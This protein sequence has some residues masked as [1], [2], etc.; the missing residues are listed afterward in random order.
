MPEKND[1][2][3]PARSRSRLGRNLGIGAGAFFLLLLVLYFVVTSSTFL[4]GV[5]APQAGKELGGE[6][7]VGEARI[8]PFSQVV[9]KN[10]R[11]QTSG[12]EP[13]MQ[14]EEVR[15]RYSLRDIL[16]GTLTVHEVTLLSPALHIIEREDGSS[17]LEPVLKAVRDKEKK[18]KKEEPPP[19]LN[20]K[21][22]TLKDGS[23]RM[24]RPLKDGGRETIEISG[25]QISL[26]QLINGQ[27]GK[28]EIASALALDRPTLATDAPGGRDTLQ[29]KL[30]GGFTFAIDEN[31]APLSINGQTRLE[32]NQAGGMLQDLSALTAILDC[33]LTPTEIRNVRLHFTQ[34]GA[35]LGEVR[36]RG[37]FDAENLEAKLDVE[38]SSID[39][40]VLN[41]AGATL[42]YDF[43]PTKI[44]STN[45][46]ELAR[47]GNAVQARGQVAIS[48]FSVTQKEMTT[49]PLDLNVEYSIAADLEAKTALVE[50]FSLQGDQKQQRFLEGQLA[51]PMKIAWGETADAVDESAFDLKLT[52]LNLADWRLFT[53]DLAPDGLVDLDLKL[54]SQ[55]AGKKLAIELN[56]A[57]D[58]LT[59]QL[60]TNRLERASIRLRT[61][62]NV[63]DFKQVDLPEYRF[64][65]AQEKEPLITAQGQARYH[66]ETQAATAELDSEISLP[67]LVQFVGLPELSVQSGKAQFKGRLVQDVTISGGK[68]NTAQSVVGNVT[69]NEFT[70]SYSNY[71][72]KRL[73]AKVDCD[74]SVQNLERA[75]IRKLAGELQH[76]GKPAGQFEL[77]GQYELTKGTGKFQWQVAGLNQN[78]LGPIVQ[79]NVTDMTLVSINFGS[80]GEAAYHPGGESTIKAKLTLDDILVRDAEGK[81]P[82]TPLHLQTEVDA[83]LQQQGTNLV[84]VMV[85][86]MSG[87]IRHGNDPAGAFSVTGNYNVPRK[88][89]QFEFLVADLNQHLLGIALAPALGDQ[90]LVSA[91]F[92]A[93]GTATYDAAGDTSAKA[94]VKLEN[95]VV[96]D[97]K[98]PEP[99]APLAATVQLDG[100]MRK[101]IIDLRQFE[102]TLSPTDRAKNQ[103]QIQGQVDLS[104][105]NVYQGKLA[106]RSDALDLTPYYEMVQAGGTETAKTTPEPGK[107]AKP[108]PGAPPA[109][110][111]PEEEPAAMELP[112]RNFTLDARIGHLYLQEIAVS[113]LVAVTK[114]DDG[115][116]QLNPFELTLNG[117]PIRA[118]ADV[119]LAVTGYQ[120][121]VGL[122]AERLEIEPLANT[123]SPTYKGQ[124]QGQLFADVQV[125]GAGITGRSLQQNL[126]GHA[127][128]S[129]TNANIQLVGPKAKAILTPISLVLG[130]PEILKSPLNHLYAD[131]GIAK[132]EVNVRNFVAN[133]PAFIGES[134]GK[135]PLADVLLD[136]PVNLPIEVSLPRSLAKRFS[137]TGVPP[138][139]TYVKLP[140]F[141]RIEGTLGQW[142]VKT[143][144]TVLAGLMMSGA[145]GRVGGTVGGVL[146]GLGGILTQPGATNTNAAPNTTTNQP[147]QT[148]QPPPVLNPFDLFKRQPKK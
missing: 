27:S 54:V 28:L 101:D 103:L 56:S 62:M 123:F 15:L 11:F 111:A 122:K 138:E 22:V 141:A 115:R 146:Q 42:G 130:I 45:R 44:N 60:E 30:A 69:L 68:T 34:A 126:Q 148:N 129:F 102:L 65:L 125:K 94:S 105:T 33:D 131:V 63:D 95:L 32:V 80:T 143:D 118:Q 109:P 18:E 116:V 144:K 117:T 104:Q 72:F 24:D 46:I 35:A 124:A 29:A 88:T 107:P 4:K 110:P 75:E 51:Q 121:D 139:V 55:Q 71:H 76:D 99:N 25:L 10:V 70:G 61:R 64:E 92:N 3:P 132:G 37:P 113:N 53:G 57:L 39:R 147:P 41:L 5:I 36:V 31:L 73:I 140:T 134:K 112:F 85:K 87:T 59:L 145:A 83:A 7:T 14:A 93:S 12:E 13:L 114:I 8:S 82:A 58:Q 90:Q 81:F 50:T 106:V 78:L 43:G 91:A 23:L 26:D 86:K 100:S 52:R 67:R 96:R 17:N 89:G 40:Q 137:L 127:F 49:P 120:Y 84:Q 142:E 98:K 119:N 74:L 2:A 19:R 79:P 108:A 48:Q 6:L 1:A 38:I 66:L 128:L 20:I 16:G 77:G 97:P 47:Q 133:S 135:I 9:L 21:N 136:S